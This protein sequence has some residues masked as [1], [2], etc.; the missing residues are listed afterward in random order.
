VEAVAS[1]LEGLQL[2]GSVTLTDATLGAGAPDT[3]NSGLPL[4]SKILAGVPPVIGNL[5]VIYS[6]R[7]VAGL[8]FKADWHG[9]GAR[10]TEDPLRR[11]SYTKIPTYNYFNFGAGFVIPNAGARI[12]LD[13]L[14]AFQSKG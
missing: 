5:A 13:L 3:M 2:L 4:V 8:H 12:S 1:P 9:V 10:Y 7:R 11:V 6:P 14:N